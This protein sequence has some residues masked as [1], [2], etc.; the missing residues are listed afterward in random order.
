MVYLPRSTLLIGSHDTGSDGRLSSLRGEYLIRGE[1]RFWPEAGGADGHL[2]LA[3]LCDAL[4]DA[5]GP[6][7]IRLQSISFAIL[8]RKSSIPFQIKQNHIGAPSF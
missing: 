1:N 6:A 4:S 5:I 8:R 2:R 7:R 3:M